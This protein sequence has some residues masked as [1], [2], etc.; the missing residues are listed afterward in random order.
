MTPELP[1]LRDDG[2][3]ASRLGCTVCTDGQLGFLFR[4]DTAEVFFDC[5][6]CMSGF[7]V[8]PGG[9]LSA[10]LCI[11]DPVWDFRPATPGENQS[12][13]LGASMELRP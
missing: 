3:I 7:M 1:L 9:G 12:S 4:A 8:V 2:V 13:G 10:G 5:V 6:E 11:N